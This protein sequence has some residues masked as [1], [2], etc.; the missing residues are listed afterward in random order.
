M[1]PIFTANSPLTLVDVTDV[2]RS[3]GRSFA[4]WA[5]E[6]MLIPST[7]ML[8]LSVPGD[9]KSGVRACACATWSDES[10]T[11]T[12]MVAVA[13]SAGLVWAGTGA[14]VAPVV[15]PPHEASTIAAPAK[16][17]AHRR[18][19]ASYRRCAASRAV[20]SIRLSSAVFDRL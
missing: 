9:M 18:N 6:T 20:S 13:S 8:I 4:I 15:P 5:S 12:V 19:P 16:S 11:R 10:G 7:R 17:G 1:K 3:A 14:L 2:K